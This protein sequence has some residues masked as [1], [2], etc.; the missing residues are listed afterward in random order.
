MINSRG[1]L[2]LCLFRDDAPNP[3]ETGGPRKF[4]G[5]VGEIGDWGHPCRDGV[6]WEGG[7]G[8]GA[9]GGWMGGQGMEYG[10]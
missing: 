7:V 5:Q 2:G 3:E 4:R 9:D 6:G 10:V 8:C 1:L